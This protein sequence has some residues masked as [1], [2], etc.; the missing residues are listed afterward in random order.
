MDDWLEHMQHTNPHNR[1][2]ISCNGRVLAET[3]WAVPISTSTQRPDENKNHVYTVDYSERRVE[4]GDTHDKRQEAKSFGHAWKDDEEHEVSNS[5][6]NVQLLLYFRQLHLCHQI[7]D[8]CGLII[9][10][11]VIHSRA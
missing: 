5:G 10:K 1:T 7:I 11:I 3:F 2:D 6:R 8:K 4:R 9:I